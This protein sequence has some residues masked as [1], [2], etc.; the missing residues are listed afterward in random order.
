MAFTIGPGH[1]RIAATPHIRKGHRRNMHHT[2][3]TTTNTGAVN[4][5]SALKNHPAIETLPLLGK[6]ALYAEGLL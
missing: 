1:P 4:G 3:H 2:G 6:S 5:K